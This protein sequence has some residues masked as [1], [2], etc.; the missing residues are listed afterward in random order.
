M[1]VGP[2]CLLYSA[3]IPGFCYYKQGGGDLALEAV[4]Y[5]LGEHCALELFLKIAMAAAHSHPFL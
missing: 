5:V 3:D 4:L 2:A 1:L